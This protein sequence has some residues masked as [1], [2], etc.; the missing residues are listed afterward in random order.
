MNYRYAPGTAPER[1]E[2]SLRAMLPGRGPRGLGN[3]PP[4][5]VNAAD[6]LVDRLAPHGLA[7][8]PAQAGV[9]ARR[10]VRH[11][12]G[13]AVNFG[14]GDPQVRSSDDERVDATALVRSYRGA[15]RL[16][17]WGSGR[18]G[19]RG[20][21]GGGSWCICHRGSAR[22]SR[23]RSRSS[24]AARPPPSPPGATVIDFGV[25]DPREVTAPLHPRGAAGRDRAHLVVPARGRAARTARRDRRLGASG[26]SARLDPDTQSCRCWV[27]RSSCSRS[28]RPSSTRAGASDLVDRHARPATRS[29]SAARGSPAATVAPPAAARAAGF[30]PDLD[31]VDDA[32]WERTAILWLN[33]PNNPTGAVA[34]LAFLREAA[35]ARARRTACCWRPTRRTASC[36]ST[37]RPPRGAPAGRPDE[38][39]GRQHAVEALVDDRVPQRVRGRRPAI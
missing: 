22:W 2:A 5:P 23:T 33:Y 4:G 12:R 8:G 14:P 18:R 10:R 32:T 36:G 1:A 6:P 3:A 15:V 30:L 21:R 26:G 27:R 28:P 31:G 29:R 19:V 34:P 17:G 16:P 11:D 35:D 25:G 7:R 20:A 9:D 37:S 24:I 13:D 39:P 38:R